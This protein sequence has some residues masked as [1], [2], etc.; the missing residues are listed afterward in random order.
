M[1]DELA[2]ARADAALLEVTLKA[3][4]EQKVREA[5]DAAQKAA[6]VSHRIAIT[7]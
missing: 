4:A 3:A 2:Q 1:L 6:T 5:V 7:F